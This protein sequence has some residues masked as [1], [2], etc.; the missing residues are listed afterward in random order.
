MF[1]LN[2]LPGKL[3][4]AIAVILIAAALLVNL[5]IHKFFFTEQGPKVECSSFSWYRA[6][7]KP[8]AL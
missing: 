6:I 2:N 8:K 4:G 7:C 1:L 5:L 3:V